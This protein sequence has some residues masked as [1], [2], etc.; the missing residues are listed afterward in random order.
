MAIAGISRAATLALLVLTWTG[1]TDPRSTP[2]QATPTQPA[3]TQAAPEP[4]VEEATPIAIKKDELGKPTWNPAWDQIVE[5]ALPPELLSSH[6]ARDVRPFCP[7]FKKMS[8]VDKRAFW[9]YFFQALSGAEAGLS[10]TSDVR[11]PEV[12]VRDTVTHR[13]VRAKACCS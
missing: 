8:D 4:K 1:Q 2:A 6:V 9:A 12:D 5:D 13:M 11:H 10:P 3:P 7:R